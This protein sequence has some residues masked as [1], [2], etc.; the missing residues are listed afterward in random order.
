MIPH[1]TFNALTPPACVSVT[2]ALKHEGPAGG[3]FI[4]TNITRG[5]QDYTY[6]LKPRR[7]SHIVLYVYICTLVDQGRGI[8]CLSE[9]YET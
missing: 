8:C 5:K 7:G 2:A 3:I 4:D 6:S 9:R 1:E